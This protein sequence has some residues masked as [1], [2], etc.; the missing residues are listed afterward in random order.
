MWKNFLKIT[1]NEIIIKTIPDILNIFSSETLFAY[2]AANPA[3][4]IPPIDAIANSIIGKGL[5][6][7]WPI[8]PERDMKAM[9][10][11]EVPTAIFIG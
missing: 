4:I 3:P 7:K 8:P 9:I 1:T 2:L 11:T 10:N 5:P 6:M